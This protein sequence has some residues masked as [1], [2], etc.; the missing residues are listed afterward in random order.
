MAPK[1]T[2]SPI[3]NTTNDWLFAFAFVQST[4]VGQMIL[5]FPSRIRDVKS[6]TFYNKQSTIFLSLDE[7][8]RDEKN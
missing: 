6:H 8:R 2:T 4:K 7:S 5:S 1:F 3:V